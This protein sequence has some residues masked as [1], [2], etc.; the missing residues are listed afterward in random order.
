MA[1]LNKKY[2]NCTGIYVGEPDGTGQCDPLTPT[3]PDPCP[4]TFWDKASGWD[5]GSISQNALNWSYALGFLTPPN[6]NLELQLYQQELERQRRQ[7]QMIMIGLV[8]VLI[9]ILVVVFAKRKK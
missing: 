7:S 9:I 6:Q 1:N 4:E 8:I 2:C 3:S 5:W